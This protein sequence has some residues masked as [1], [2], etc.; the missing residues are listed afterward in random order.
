MNYCCLFHDILTVDSQKNSYFWKHINAFKEPLRSTEVSPSKT[1]DICSYSELQQSL[2][3]PAFTK[4]TSID[5]KT[6]LKGETETGVTS[7]AAQGSL[8]A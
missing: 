1:E 2:I 3:E 4:L 8:P 7:L 6:G 5:C